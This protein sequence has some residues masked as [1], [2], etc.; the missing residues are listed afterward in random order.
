MNRRSITIPP[1]E[2]IRDDIARK[3]QEIAA[4]KKLLAMAHAARIGLSA[5]GRMPARQNG[6]SD[7]R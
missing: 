6:G 1:P 4:L 2:Q 7:A 5:P 3:R